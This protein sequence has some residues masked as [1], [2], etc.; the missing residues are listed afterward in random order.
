[1]IALLIAA[2]ASTATPLFDGV[3]HQRIDRIADGKPMVGHVIE[4]DLTKSVR[5]AMTPADRS[6][7]MEHVARTVSDELIRRRA[8]VAVNASYFLPFAGG[9]QGADDYYPLAGEGASVSGAVIAGGRQVSPVEI[10]QDLRVS[11]ILCIGRAVTIRDGQRCPNGTRDAIAAGPRLLTDGAPSSLHRSLSGTGRGPR[12]AVG[13]AAD[14]KRAWIV[15]IDG[16]QEGYSMGASNADLIALFG[17]LG[18]RD[19]MS[20]DGGGSV[21]LAVE[22]GGK[23]RLLNRPI[24]TGVPGRERPV[25]NH[26]VVFARPKGN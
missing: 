25:A 6:Q 14:G 2:A 4:L 13:V 10:D 3:A 17:E 9:S 8:Q 22:D 26:L 23:A 19:A 5:L 15:V 18:A 12:T 20:F 7:G 11:A 16:R 1:V 24:H 21:A